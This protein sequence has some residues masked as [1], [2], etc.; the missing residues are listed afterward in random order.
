MRFRSIAL[1]PNIADAAP[2][3]A[4]VT[5]LRCPSRRVCIQADRHGARGV[6]VVL[7]ASVPVAE[8]L[9]TIVELVDGRADREATPRDVAT[10][11]PVGARRERRAVV[12]A[13][14]AFAMAICSSSTPRTRRGSARCAPNRASGRSRATADR[15]P[16]ARVPADCVVRARHGAGRGGAGLGP[17]APSA[18]RRT[19]SSPPPEQRSRCGGDGARAIRR[20]RAFRWSPWP[21]RRASSPC[22]RDRRRRTSSSPR[23]PRCPQS[24]LTM[25]L[26]G[27]AVAGVDCDCRR[28]ASDGTGD[29][30]S[31]ARRGPV[32]AA[33]RPPHLSLLALAPRT[34]GAGGRSR[35]GRIGTTP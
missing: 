19:R 26:S 21:A 28:V 16:L 11:S 18:P 17:W 24:L 22:R 35:A 4:A 5:V 8:L 14:M 15:L 13:T 27:A 3:A 12:D 1:P 23:R 32:G 25:R 10:G 6:D 33:L 20:R 2:P 30:G 29:A 31:R 9:P 34:V 7:P